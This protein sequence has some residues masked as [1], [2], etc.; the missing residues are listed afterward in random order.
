MNSAIRCSHPNGVSNLF[1]QIV[2]DQGFQGC[3]AGLQ[4]LESRLGQPIHL[5]HSDLL[6]LI[7]QQCRLLLLL[8]ASL[9]CL[10]DG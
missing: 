9:L 10:F 6:Q 4:C 1:L 7:Q 5:T 2:A 3:P 8:L